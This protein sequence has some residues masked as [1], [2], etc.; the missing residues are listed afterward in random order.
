MSVGANIQKFRKGLG[1]SQEELGNRLLV[2]RQTI[3]LWEKDQTVP[4]IDNLMR[5]KEVFGVSTDEILG[6][7]NSTPC[8]KDETKE[9]YRFNFDKTELHDVYRSQNWLLYKKPI[10]FTLILVLLLFF[11][12]GSSAPHFLVGVIFGI[13]FLG[14]IHHIKTIRT[15]R[16][17]QKTNID[18][19]SATTYDY[20]IFNDYLVLKT[21]RN[22]ELFG[23]YKCYFSE[24]ERIQHL[25]RWLLLQFGRRTYILRKSDLNENSALYSIMYRNPSK[26]EEKSIPSKWKV[27]SDVLFLASL[28]SMPGAIA[29]ESWVSS[30]NGLGVENMWLFFLLTPIPISSAIFAI[31]LKSHGYHYKK[32]L[33]AGI[34]VTVLLCIYGSFTFIF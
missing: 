16:K 24:I 2:S 10:I 1:M 26:T 29:L 30:C 28:L 17:I 12:I 25:D 13:L 9:T 8:A 5:L 4:T 33:I 6:F 27:I 31:V 34:I 20:K 21:Y 7:S 3:S 15:Y 18:Q 22:N 23:E 32:N 19:I 14:T 11:Y